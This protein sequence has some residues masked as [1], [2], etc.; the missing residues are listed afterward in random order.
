MNTRKIVSAK[1]ILLFC[2]LLALCVETAILFNVK[3]T[4]VP[5]GQGDSDNIYDLNALDDMDAR[6]VVDTYLRSYETGAKNLLTLRLLN[7]GYEKSEEFLLK[8]SDAYNIKSVTID[9]IEEVYPDD[10]EIEEIRSAASERG[11]GSPDQITDVKK[12]YV[13][14]G[15]SPI[16]SGKV[17]LMDQTERKEFIVLLKCFGVWKI[18]GQGADIGMG[19]YS[20]Q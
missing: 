1:N 19:V 13:E 6:D 20:S 10:S 11:F 7:R 12:Y 9:R 8:Y 3:S 15:I 17:L 2:L 18:Y 5:Y 14:Y 16:D 4:A